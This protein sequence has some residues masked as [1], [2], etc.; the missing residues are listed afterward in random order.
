[1]DIL[2]HRDQLAEALTTAVQQ[3][4]LDMA[5]AEVNV[6]SIEQLAAPAALGEVTVCL[7]LSA[8]LE[9]LLL[10]SCS[11]QTADAL[12]RRILTGAAVELNPALLADCLGEIV[13]VVAGQAKALLA[14]T[15]YHFHFSP[16]S[17]VSADDLR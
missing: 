14:G 17:I 3:A 7:K 4:F 10:L 9:G 15:P 5:G 2:A 12:A 6:R 11:N 13:N 16:P 1:M 8:T